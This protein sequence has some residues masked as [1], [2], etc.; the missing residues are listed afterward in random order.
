MI[1]LRLGPK[2]CHRCFLAATFEMS[3]VWLF[4]APSCHRSIH[5]ASCIT[6]SGSEATDS[7]LEDFELK[8]RLPSL[9]PSLVIVSALEETNIVPTL[10]EVHPTR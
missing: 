2:W 6:A 9:H 4:P 8:L 10:S 5:R 7:I 3:D 1:E